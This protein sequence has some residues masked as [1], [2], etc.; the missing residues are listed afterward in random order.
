MQIFISPFFLQNPIPQSHHQLCNN[1]PVATSFP[2]SPLP[3]DLPLL[4]S[5]PQLTTLSHSLIPA[6][7]PWDPQATWAREGGVGQLQIFISPSILPSPVPQSHPQISRIPP[8]PLLILCPCSHGTRWALVKDS[9]FL[10]S[11]EPLTPCILLN[12]HS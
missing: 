10:P 2:F 1:P 12:R 6:G 5:L 3:I 11:V 4:T 8:T 9:V 7:T